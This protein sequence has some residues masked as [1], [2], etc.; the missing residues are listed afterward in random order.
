MIVPFW[1]RRVFSYT[2]ESPVKVA[3]QILCENET[4]LWH[5]NGH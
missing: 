5:L 4:N 3:I 2:R 1:D